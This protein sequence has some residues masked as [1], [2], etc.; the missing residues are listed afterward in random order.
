MPHVASLL[1]P[2]G[3]LLMTL[4]HGPVPTGRF[5]FEV[6]PEETIAL[7]QASGLHVVAS[8]LT[9]STQRVNRDAGIMWSRLAFVR[10]S[11]EQEGAMSNAA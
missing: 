3:I 7:V 8:V 10:A 1:E 6:S 5:M 2:K 9:P 4:R 11:N